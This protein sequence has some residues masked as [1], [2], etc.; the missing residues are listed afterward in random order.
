MALEE[1]TAAGDEDLSP[2]AALLL[3]GLLGTQGEVAG[4]R[5]LLERAIASGHFEVARRASLTLGSLLASQEDPN[6]VGFFEQAAAS[7][8]REV[9]AQAAL[10]LASYYAEQKDLA[11]TQAAYQQAID[12]HHPS[13]SVKAAAARWGAAGQPRR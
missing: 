10:C 5:A 3:G 11:R 9:A 7:G 13:F 4:A 1:Q 12:A 6:Q 2:R 8:R